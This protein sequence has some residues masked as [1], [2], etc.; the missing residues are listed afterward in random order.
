M[1]SCYTSAGRAAWQ[2][3]SGVLKWCSVGAYK[4]GVVHEERSVVRAAV[5]SSFQR[6][7]AKVSAPSSLHPLCSGMPWPSSQRVSSARC[8]GPWI[9]RYVNHVLPCLLSCLVL[10]WLKWCLFL[11]A[12]LSLKTLSLTLTSMQ[13]RQIVWWVLL[14]HHSL[15]GK[16][17]L[18][19]CCLRYFLV[20][21]GVPWKSLEMACFDTV[22]C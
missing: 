5:F 3:Y 16:Y 22:P 6:R 9:K 12:L 20:L 15:D 17:L 4:P 11:S 2:K 13:K 18:L 7:Q 1:H 10:G 21:G 14:T 8:S 19:T